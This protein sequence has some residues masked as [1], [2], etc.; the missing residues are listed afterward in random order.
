MNKKIDYPKIWKLFT[1]GFFVLSWIILSVIT[2]S[3]LMIIPIIFVYLIINALIFKSYFL[4]MVGNFY[5]LSNKKD[6]ALKIY[7]KAIRINTKNVI[8]LYYYALELLNNGNGKEA[9]K[10]L[11]KAY[12][13][14]TNTLLEKDIILTIGDCYWITNQID[15]AI[16]TLESLK[17]KYSYVNADVLTTLGYLYFLKNDYEKAIQYSKEAIEDKQEHA[18]AWDNLGQIYFKQKNYE[19]AK[20]NFLKALEYRK[21][22][23]DSLYYLG[24]IY[25]IE[26][27]TEK[28]AEYFS[29]A[30][31]CNISPLNTV[32][33][34]QVDSKY[35]EYKQYNIS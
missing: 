18:P 34:E 17:Q 14:N 3:K 4:G 24:E 28:A 31:K 29:Q 26:N 32:T 10:Y 2:I 15:K 12:E 7:E 8:T 20:E 22:M 27:N 35:N 13:L 1:L 23:V 11:K 30:V 25:G 21:S 19:K 33:K 16:E 9:L 5:Y 6:K